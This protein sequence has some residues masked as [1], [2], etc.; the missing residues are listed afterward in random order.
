MVTAK[1]FQGVDVAKAVSKAVTATEQ[2]TKA[3]TLD[4]Q[5]APTLLTVNG[6]EPA[7][8]RAFQNLIVN[9]ATH[10]GKGGWIGVIGVTDEECV[11][12]MVEIQ[13]ADRGQGIAQ[14]ELAEIFEPFYRG[15]EAEAGQIRG[16]GL[17]LSLVKEIV[18]AHGGSVS[19]E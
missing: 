14:E 15:S 17:G 8:Q 12:A 11:P 2:E 7:L 4:L 1:T 16:S 6:D 18:E 10:G 9:A 13:V 5:L 3:C 19:V